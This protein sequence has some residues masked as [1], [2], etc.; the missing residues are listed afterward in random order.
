M[1]IG[2]HSW[3]EMENGWHKKAKHLQRGDR[4]K[5]GFTVICAVCTLLKSPRSLTGIERPL[6]TLLVTPGHPIN[7]DDTWV[8][9]YTAPGATVVQ[10]VRIHGPCNEIYNFVLSEGHFITIEGMRCI[11]LGHGF[12]SPDV[13]HPYSS[14]NPVVKNLQRMPGWEN[15]LILLETIH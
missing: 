15:G 3:V 5:D 6:G 11:T 2:G 1:G 10:S 4:V 12:E 14:T 13:L 9:S 7:V 8:P